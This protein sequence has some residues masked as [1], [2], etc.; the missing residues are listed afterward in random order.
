MNATS[1]K[2]FTKK[3]SS[4]S[5]P[6]KYGSE[7]RSGGQHESGKGQIHSQN[8]PTVASR[9]NHNQSNMTNP[10]NQTLYTN[11]SL[12]EISHSPDAAAR[13][14]DGG[15]DGKILQP[16]KPSSRNKRS[17]KIQITSGKHGGVFNLQNPNMI[18]T[19]QKQLNLSRTGGA[20]SALGNLGGGNM[21]QTNT[22]APIDLNMSH[23]SH[24]VETQQSLGQMGHMLSN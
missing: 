13:R 3:T 5:V 23:L 11:I 19:S 1:S 22:Q 15:A 20:A 2:A 12:R 10:Q 8:M 21:I 4:G 24:N 17:K 7:T 16:R 9:N 18:N 14:D 6:L